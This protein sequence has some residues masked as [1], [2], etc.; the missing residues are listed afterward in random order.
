[1][2]SLSHLVI[3]S[4]LEALVR[5]VDRPDYYWGAV[6]PDIR[7]LAGMRRRQ[8]HLATHEIVA[9]LDRYPQLR[10]FVQ[11]YLVHCLADQVDLAEVL[12]RRLPFSLLKDRLTHQQLAVLLDLYY[13]DRPPTGLSLSGTH[14]AF[15]SELGVSRSVTE[16]FARCM[17]S[18]LAPASPANLA[19]LLRSMGLETD[20]RV[21]RYVAAARSFQQSRALKNAL[22]LGI[23]ANRIGD[24]I[25]RRVAA[26]YQRCVVDA[27]H[28]PA[29]SRPEDE[30]SSSSGP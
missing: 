4:R 21:E 9:R 26:R 24:R 23:R 10:S 27:P 18:Y 6:V 30:P 19:A 11:G 2:N 17:R 13:L 29:K 7:Y 5:P 28:L 25:V 1:M 15:L 16:Q 22:F 12:M 8:T 3:A 20:R 14:N